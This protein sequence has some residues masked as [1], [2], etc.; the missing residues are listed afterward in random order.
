MLF[1]ER[2]DD[3]DDDD[4]DSRVL[5]SQV[6]RQTDGHR[7]AS[8]PLSSLRA[9]QTFQSFLVGTTGETFWHLWLDIERART[10]YDDRQL[11]R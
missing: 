10:I 1:V 2:E 7:A 11:A 9:V 8:S 6:G 4:D 5:T 3:D